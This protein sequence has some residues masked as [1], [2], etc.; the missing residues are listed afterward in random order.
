MNE[1]SLCF[2]NIIPSV[3]HV[4]DRYCN[5]TWHVPPFQY[6]IHNFMLVVSGEGTSLTDSS[7]Y[8]M[9]SGMLVYHHCGQTFGFES[10]KTNPMHCFGV[11][12]QTAEIFHESGCWS[13]KNVEKLPFDNFIR[14]LDMDILIKYFSDLVNVW[15]ERSKNRN[16]KIRSLFLNILF[17]VSNQIVMQQ[18]NTETL[19]SI[20]YAKSFIRKNYTQCLTLDSLAALTG[21]NSNYFGSVFKKYTGKTPIEYVNFVRVENAVELLRIGCSVAEAASLTGFHDPFYFSK[22]FKKTKGVSPRDYRKAP[23]N[24]C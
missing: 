9:Y 16:L 18:C 23:L 12:F 21:L 20:E 4:A 17:E 7:R 10:S 11:N 14:V 1:N 2:E 5:D 24:F 8:D 13:A 3:F 6:G 19:Q 22:V 15:D